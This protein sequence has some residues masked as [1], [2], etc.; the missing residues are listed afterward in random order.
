MLPRLAAILILC[1][2]FSVM[3]SQ[4]FIC[5]TEVPSNAQALEQK[6]VVNKTFAYQ[7]ISTCLHKTLSIHVII[8][9]DSLNNPGVSSANITGAVQFMNT[10]YAP[11][12]MSFQVCSIDTVYSYRY[13]RWNRT[14]ME[15][16]FKVLYCKENVINLVLVSTLLV[17]SGAAGYAPL[18]ILTP[19]VPR[20]DI[21]CIQKSSINPTAVVL[22]HEMGHYFGLYHT[23]ETS[24]GVEFVNESNCATT[25]DLLCDTPAAI[26]PSPMSGCAWTGTTR[27]PNGDLY[28]PSMGNIMSYDP[29]ACS[30]FFTT[31]QY[32]RIIFSYLNFRNYIY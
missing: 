30:P 26:N 24:L 11:I 27:D 32:N 16:E 22:P 9:T 10:L 3:R 2:P 17:P 1:L 28:T 6:S 14:T 18:G 15:A 23:F 19:P 21:I 12:C 4:S 13:N 25:G 20:K 29:P 7:S 8:V 31:G 5:G